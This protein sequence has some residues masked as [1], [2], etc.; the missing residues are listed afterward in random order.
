[1]TPAPDSESV[2]RR[3][4]SESELEPEI[5]CLLTHDV[6]QC[7]WQPSTGHGGAGG[8]M[9]EPPGQGRRGTSKMVYLSVGQVRPLRW[10]IYLLSCAWFD[11]TN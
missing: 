10:K 2:L 5:L 9:R 3:L 4:D 8:A 7:H 1:M 11:N 6:P